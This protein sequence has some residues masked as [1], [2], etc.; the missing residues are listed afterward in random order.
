MTW[1]LSKLS[2]KKFAGGADRCCLVPSAG[3]LDRLLRSLTI[4]VIF[5]YFSIALVEK[6]NLIEPDIVILM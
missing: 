1:P 5:I 4:L 6:V 3:G 2:I